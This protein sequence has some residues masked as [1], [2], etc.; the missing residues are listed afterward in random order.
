MRVDKLDIKSEDKILVIAP[1]P[2]DESIGVGG[3]L[4][5]VP[6]Q[7][8][9]WIMTD[10]RYGGNEYDP[11]ELKE[12]RR[13]ECVSALDYAKV[14]DVKFFD[15]T[16]GTLI[17]HKDCFD[18][19]DF[20]KYTL[21]FLPNPNDNH[22]DH[23]A[24]YAYCVS[25]L[26]EIKS[27]IRVFLYEVHTP[28]ADISC[29]TDITEVVSKKSKMISFHASQVKKHSYDKQTEVLAKYRGI[30]NEQPDLCLEVYK[31]INI[32]EEKTNTSIEVELAKYKQFTRILSKWFMLEADGWS[33]NRYI[34]EQNYE[35]VAIYGYGILG[36]LLVSKMLKEGCN[37]SYVIDKNENISDIEGN[38]MVKHRLDDLPKAD[39]V[40]VTVVSGDDEVKDELYKSSKLRSFLN[41]LY[42]I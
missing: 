25:R 3:L 24:V 32:Y 7:C 26:K 14:T 33:I 6:A 11:C 2:D 12:I 39:I 15:Y 16:D 17:Q 30:Q 8:S 27:D 5:S 18:N 29:Y 35:T 41:R 31:E 10:G 37:I 19:E 42:C 1:H 34:K 20:L 28:L 4:N 9:V 38:V 21:V 13:R 22:S 23:T 40:I 36:R